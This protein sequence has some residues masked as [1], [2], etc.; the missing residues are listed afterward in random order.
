MTH[1]AR[2]EDVYGSVSLSTQLDVSQQY[3]RVHY[4]RNIY[5]GLFERSIA[6]GQTRQESGDLPRLEKVDETDQ[7]GGR[8]RTA[9]RVNQVPDRIDNDYARL[10]L[11][12]QFVDRCQVHLQ[13]VQR[14][15]GGMKAEQTFLDP[16]LQ[17][18]ADRTH[19]A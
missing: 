12:N 18:Q 4:R 6:R 7:H 9:T 17:I 8:I 3:P 15:S 19:I 1:A 11:I 5:F 2:L 13:A 14:R 10:V 16:P